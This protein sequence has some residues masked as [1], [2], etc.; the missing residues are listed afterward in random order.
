M[1]AVLR[2]G[3][4]L[5]AATSTVTPEPFAT[6][7]AASSGVSTPT[8]RAKWLSV[9][10]GTTASGSSC[11]SATAAAAATLPSPPAPPSPRAPPRAA[12]PAPAAAGHPERLGTRAGGVLQQF[13]DAVL[14][15]D[16]ADLGA[17]EQPP[18]L[19]GR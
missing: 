19:L 1:L 2:N 5:T 4:P 15:G 9:P 8:S 12:A 17:R 10:A 6:A 18:D 11:S 13:G 16:L 14:L 7:A 3:V